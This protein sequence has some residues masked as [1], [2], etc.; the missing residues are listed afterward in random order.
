MVGLLNDHIQTLMWDDLRRAF[1]DNLQNRMLSSVYRP[2][3]STR[4]NIIKG[5]ATDTTSWI[6][7]VYPEEDNLIIRTTLARWL[8]VITLTLMVA[9][10]NIE[11][12]RPKTYL[13]KVLTEKVY[14]MSLPKE[15][16]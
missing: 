1:L 15:D 8:E 11:T 6:D 4:F 10:V 12:R 2:T 5:A 13:L 9:L 3:G 7:D 16:T 14:S